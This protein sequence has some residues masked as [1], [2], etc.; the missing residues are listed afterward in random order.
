WPARAMMQTGGRCDR[1]QLG[2]K[3]LG[4][5]TVAGWRS[6]GAL[7]RRDTPLAPRRPASPIRSA[8]RRMPARAA[9]APSVTRNDSCAYSKLRMAAIMLCGAT[10]TLACRV[11]L[12]EPNCTRAAVGARR[13]GAELALT[14]YRI[15]GKV[16]VGERWLQR[17]VPLN[18]SSLPSAKAAPVLA[19]RSP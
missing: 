19:A 15:C 16:A 10:E 5:V 8:W 11:L 1:H 6:P 17:A 12:H 9:R 14:E 3:T 4:S 2:A 13:S 18:A 7:P